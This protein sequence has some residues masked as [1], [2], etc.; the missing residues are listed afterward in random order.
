LAALLAH[1]FYTHHN[2]STKKSDNRS[3]KKHNMSQ[4]PLMKRASY[5]GAT[6]RVSMRGSI[7]GTSARRDLLKM[8]AEL[9]K[10][11][12]DPMLG[13]P[14]TSFENATLGLVGGK[15]LQCW[16]L[17]RHGFPVPTAYIIPTYVFSMH[18]G[19]AGVAKLIDTVYTSD[20]NDENSRESVKALLATIRERIALTPLN[21][22]VVNNLEAFLTG[23]PTGSFVA[24]RSSGSAEDLASQSFAGQ[25]DTFLY[26]I[27]KEDILESVK[28]CWVSMFKDHIL[29]YASRFD[30]YFPGSIKTP[31]MGVLIMKM[32]D[33]KTSGVCFSRN[34]W[35]DKREVMVEAVLGQGEGLVS[36]AITPDR[37]V[38]DKYS[39]RLCYSDISTQTQMYVRSNNTAGVELVDLA[40]PHEDP[41][42]SETNLVRLTNLARSIEDF[43]NAPQDIEWAMDDTSAIFLLQSRPITTAD[44]CKSL[45]FLPPGEGFWTFDPTVSDLV[46]HGPTSS[47]C[48]HIS[49][50]FFVP[51]LS[52]SSISLDATVLI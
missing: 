26:K 50:V 5:V 45:S 47:G 29:D 35:G 52:S 7:I 8:Q 28:L 42:M 21:P 19:D 18:V 15:A 23:L 17:A 46:L 1:S 32:V 37:Y 48:D 31:K 44:N 34:L 10:E 49:R 41:V 3:S 36:G 20:W 24:I 43:Y 51:A 4:I 9:D 38:L 16:R 2:L 33:A 22:E 40:K 30:E 6:G 12:F 27:T 13:C 25:Y 39:T 11:I 14:L